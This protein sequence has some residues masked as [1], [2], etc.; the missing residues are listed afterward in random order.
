MGKVYYDPMQGGQILR[1]KLTTPEQDAAFIA[2]L[3]KIGTPDWYGPCNNCRTFSENQFNNA[4]GVETAPPYRPGVGWNP[5][6]FS[7]T[8]QPVK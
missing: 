6:P 5:A 2:H 3:P 7:W 1:Y 4:P 8:T